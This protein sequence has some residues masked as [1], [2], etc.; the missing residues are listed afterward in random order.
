MV[1][2]PT[3]PEVSNLCMSAQ[4]ASVASALL[5]TQCAARFRTNSSYPGPEKWLTLTS[6]RA[7]TSR[8]ALLRSRWMMGGF[9]ECRQPMPRAMSMENSTYNTA[10]ASSRQK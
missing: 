1:L 3:E 6:K 2:D 10:A 4:P 5:K 9:W 7:E 8:L